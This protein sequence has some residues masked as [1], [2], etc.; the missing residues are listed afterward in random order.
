MKKIFTIT[1]LTVILTAALSFGQNYYLGTGSPADPIGS[2]CASCHNT[3]G[4]ADPVYNDWITTLHSIA[5]DSLTLPYYGYSC[6]ECHNTGWD[7]NVVNYGADEYVDSIDNN[8]FTITDPDNFARVKNVGCEVCHG[9]LGT[10]ARTLS[11]DHWTANV[12]D[13]SAENCGECHQDSHHPTF[14]E[15]ETSKHAEFP[16]FIGNWMDRNENGECYRCHHAQDFVAYLE[17]PNYDPFTFVPDG[18]LVNVTCAACHDPHSAQ[19]PGQLRLPVTGSQVIC[20][21]CHTVDID[22]V[23]VYETPHHTTSECLSG[24]ADFGYQYP[25]ETYQNSVHTFVATERCINCHV[26]MEGVGDFGEATGHTF[27][28]RFIAC[29]DAGCHGDEYYSAPGVD[30][31]NTEFQFNYEFAQTITDSLLAVLEAELMIVNPGLTHDSA[32]G[33]DYNAALYNYEAVLNEGS[34]GV[35]NTK[36]VHELLEDAIAKFD[37]TSVEYEDSGLPVTY[38]LSQNYPN[39]FNPVTEIKFSIPDAGNVTLTVYDAIGNEVEVIV[40]D[41]LPAGNYN[42][43]WDASGY[44]SGVYLY[45]IE[46]NNFK[47]VKKMVLLK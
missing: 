38:S 19:N 32:L 13:Y 3:S 44:S 6:L 41:Y 21:V 8:G 22:E 46:V 43:S 2:S 26:N 29:A 31:T 9:P 34:R 10:D 18:D 45:K 5:H 20:D 28:P 39:P 25:G 42:A 35:H 27:L 7:V 11:G 24:S 23:D 47:M 15:W 36:L 16:S 1:L 40:N 14:E 4:G 33:F 17:D 12:P 30:T 37:P